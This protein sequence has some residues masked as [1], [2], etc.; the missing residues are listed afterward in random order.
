LT[1][2][3]KIDRAALPKP[4]RALANDHVPPASDTETRLVAIWERLLKIERIGTT[5]R[6]F[7][8]GGHSL[9]AMQLVSAIQME[10]SCTVR[11]QDVFA[12]PAIKELAQLV[13]ALGAHASSGHS[14]SNDY[15][16]ELLEE[17]EW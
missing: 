17:K 1:P 3:G 12:Y 10:F 16:T 5:D 14:A 15:N 8:L 2:N 13:D 11:I 7:D 4:E 9:L 6:F